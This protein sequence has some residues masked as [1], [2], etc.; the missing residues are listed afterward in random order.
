M[1]TKKAVASAFLGQAS[2]FFHLRFIV[3]R[4]KQVYTELV[5]E[6]LLIHYRTQM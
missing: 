6:A 1:Y 3:A 5:V 4:S 2:R